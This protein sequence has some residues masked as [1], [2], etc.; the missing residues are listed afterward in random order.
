MKNP[1]QVYEKIKENFILYVETAFS[2]RYKGLEERR[3]KLLNADKV[4][5]RAPWIEPLPTY[6]LSEYKI[7]DIPKLPNLSKEELEIFKEYN[8]SWVSWRF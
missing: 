4:F 5:S 6:K 8:A 3:K 7:Q 2:T 1:I